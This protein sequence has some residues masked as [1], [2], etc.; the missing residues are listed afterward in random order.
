MEADVPPSP[1]HDS[2][3]DAWN[4]MYAYV[5]GKL[6]AGQ[7]SYQ[8]LETAIWI[9][10]YAPHPQNLPIMF[11]DARDRAIDEFNWTQPK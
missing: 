8:M 2:F 7:M 6:Q 5:N 3:L 9:K 11:Y 1:I 4:D 10:P